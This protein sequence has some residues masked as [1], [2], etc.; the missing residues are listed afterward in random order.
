MLLRLL[1]FL[2]FRDLHLDFLAGSV[3]RDIF[4]LLIFVDSLVLG[5]LDC[6]DPS[7]VRSVMESR[8]GLDGTGHVGELDE[9]IALGL[10]GFGVL[11]NLDLLDFPEGNQQL[12][13]QFFIDVVNEV[14]QVK[15]VLFLKAW[16]LLGAL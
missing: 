11:G 9:G 12:F 3:E 1:H 14:L 8:N 10:V 13:E 15:S 5:E 7:L 16:V 4:G 6:N 2:Q